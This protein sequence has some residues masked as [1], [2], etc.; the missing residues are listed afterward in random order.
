VER[1]D[2]TLK[3]AGS[4]VVN[5]NLAPGMANPQH[6]TGDHHAHGFTDQPPRHRIGIAVD[7][8]HAVGLHLAH[9]LARHLKWSNTGD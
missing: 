8:D 6:A 9:Q 2:N 4:A 7:L 5:R 3:P 1:V